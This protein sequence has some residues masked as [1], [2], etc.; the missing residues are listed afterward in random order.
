MCTSSL[1]L[2]RPLPLEASIFNVV[3]KASSISSLYLLF[4]CS[5]LSSIP[6]SSSRDISS[7]I[8]EFVIVLMVTSKAFGSF[9]ATISTISFFEMIAPMLRSSF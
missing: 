1:P 5:Y 4:L 3:T 2:D 7:I 8:L 6:V 9:P